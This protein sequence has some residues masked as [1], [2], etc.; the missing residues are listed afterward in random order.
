MGERDASSA[1]GS[2]ARCTPGRERRFI[3]HPDRS[4]T[5]VGR[6]PRE[7]TDELRMAMEMPM[8]VD[9]VKRQTGPAIKVELGAGLRFS[10]VRDLA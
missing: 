7:Q 3:R 6:D 8:A 9:M 5:I 2:V 10:L 1:D 4:N